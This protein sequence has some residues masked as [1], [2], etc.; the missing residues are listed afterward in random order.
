MHGITDAS[1]NGNEENPEHQAVVLRWT[2]GQRSQK[3]GSLEW[4]Q[5][6]QEG[7]A[8]FFGRQPGRAALDERN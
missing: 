2:C 8:L 5:R 1:D 4:L 6:Y 3:G 7:P